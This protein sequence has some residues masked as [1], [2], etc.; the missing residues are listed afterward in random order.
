MSSLQESAVGTLMK[1]HGIAV[2]DSAGHL[3]S[4]SPFSL[5]LLGA[6]MS[7][8]SVKRSRQKL[9][10]LSYSSQQTLSTMNM[11]IQQSNNA[12]IKMAIADFF[13]CENIPDSVV[14]SLRFIRL[15]RVCRLV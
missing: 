3:S 11:D 2:S 12:T 10:A 14:E 1:K 7:A 8:A 9:F 15:V 4:V 6:S 5:T 13:H